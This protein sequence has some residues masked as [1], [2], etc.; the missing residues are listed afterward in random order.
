MYK[1]ACICMYVYVS[2]CMCVC[3]CVYVCV[4]V[5]I[6][7]HSFRAFYYMCVCMHVYCICN[8]KTNK[9]EV[10]KSLVR[11]SSSAQ[12][13]EEKKDTC[14]RMYVCIIYG[15]NCPGREMSYPK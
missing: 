4:Y 7:I 9:Q 2:I 10:W 14:I 6:F 8:Q 5:C 12:P 1:Y 15:G 13:T 11:A 3:M